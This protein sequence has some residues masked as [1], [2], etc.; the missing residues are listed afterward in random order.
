MIRPIL[1][2]L[3]TVVFV[4]A[5]A[6]TASVSVPV[7]Q[8]EVEHQREFTLAQALAMPTITA[9]F[10]S[11]GPIGTLVTIS[12]TGFSAKNDVKFRNDDVSFTANSPVKSENGIN[13]QFHVNSCPSYEP[14]CPA[15][16][17]PPGI[18]D[19]TVVN[20]GGTSNGATF[21]LTSR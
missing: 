12:G 2:S 20:D 5:L 15:F 3:L 10:P 13:M 21:V 1:S 7:A 18:Y 19:V 9:L 11:S 14:R 4:S 16:F 8:T 17:V 6:P